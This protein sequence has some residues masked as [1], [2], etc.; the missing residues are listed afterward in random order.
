M[1]RLGCYLSKREAPPPFPLWRRREGMVR[2]L[3]DWP[4]VRDV[5]RYSLCDRNIVSSGTRDRKEKLGAWFQIPRG[6]CVIGFRVGRFMKRR[7]RAKIG[8]NAPDDRLSKP[9]S[10]VTRPD[11]RRQLSLRLA[12]LLPHQICSCSS[13]LSAARTWHTA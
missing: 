1:S 10:F 5:E 12:A 13:T 11:P 4:A 9:R 3:H 7:V 2:D 6:S 8:I